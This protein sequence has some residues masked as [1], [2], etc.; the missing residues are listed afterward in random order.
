MT[1]F[2]R[3]KKIKNPSKTELNPHKN[4]SIISQINITNYGQLFDVLSTHTN[5]VYS[6][7]DIDKRLHGKK[8]R[9]GI[10]KA[11]LFE[12]QLNM[13]VLDLEQSDCLLGRCDDYR[14][15]S[16][17]AVESMMGKYFKSVKNYIIS[18]SFSSVGSG[19]L[20]KWHIWILFKTPKPISEIRHWVM[21]MLPK[22]SYKVGLSTAGAKLK[23]NAILDLAVLDTPNR[24]IY[25]HPLAG[26]QIE[27]IGGHEAL[28]DKQLNW[29]YHIGKEI[30]P[31]WMPVFTEEIE[32]KFIDKAVAA[33]R[34]G[35]GVSFD[36]HEYRQL[37]NQTKDTLPMNFV[38]DGMTVAG[39]IKAGKQRD[40]MPI[41]DSDPKYDGKMTYY[42]NH[43]S[44]E[45][46]FK[47]HHN[48][49]I[50]IPVP[51]AKA[52]AITLPYYGKYKPKTIFKET[53]KVALMQSETGSGKTY[54]YEKD[55][56][57]IIIVPTNVMV[58][59]L[60]GF[61]KGK[62]PE[63]LKDRAMVMTYDKFLGH[64]RVGS[65]GCEIEEFT[66]VVDE[67]HLLGD[68]EASSEIFSLFTRQDHPFKRVIFTSATPNI[69]AYEQYCDEIIV[70]KREDKVAKDITFIEIT[71]GTVPT[72]LTELKGT[73]LLFVQDKKTIDKLKDQFKGVAFT[74]N[75][76]DDLDLNQVIKDNS[77]IYITSAVREGFS[78]TEH[79]D[80]VVM[81]STPKYSISP[82]DVVQI[83]ARVRNNTPNIYLPH[84]SWGHS[85]IKKR[86][87]YIRKIKP[88]THWLNVNK[89]VY[90]GDKSTEVEELLKKHPNY[91]QQ[92][93]RKTFSESGAIRVH[94]QLRL[95]NISHDYT[96]TMFIDEMNRYGSYNLVI[97]K[98]SYK[99]SVRIAVNPTLSGS[100][101]AGH[102]KD[103]SLKEQI[104]YI[105]GFKGD[106][107]LAVRELPK[108]M[109]VWNK[110]L[111]I[112]KDAITKIIHNWRH[113][114]S[115]VMSATVANALSMVASDP[116]DAIKR[117][118]RI[119][120]KQAH[121]SRMFTSDVTLEIVGH[122]DMR[123]V[124]PIELL[125]LELLEMQ[126]LD[127]LHLA[128]AA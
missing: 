27:V 107:E 73:T 37:L 92:M 116:E 11:S 101:S 69:E 21:S 55:P 86:K 78:I 34:K 32:V 93:Y 106:N 56:Q 46:L 114:R 48:N 40:F 85:D 3:G 112:Q 57:V 49:I 104:E 121:K 74:A 119:E 124:A 77:F 75:T 68:R 96:R 108:Y 99:S 72:F 39:I 35:C 64:Y 91:K 54:Q 20:G 53:T 82:V 81:L 47:D 67:C 13:C 65:L 7:G 42:P 63:Y 10:R 41:L 43:D 126:G 36:E 58:A 23:R 118:K 59:G 94:T 9:N 79:V 66:L 1:L 89:K 117:V 15:D 87:S 110:H 14:L 29:N 60:K 12:S 28:T 115:V 123:L 98:R 51:V 45:P 83:S 19:V 90:N 50:Y 88:F 122:K 105:Y 71:H 109:C 52:K 18:P 113:S 120:L 16:Y 6:P 31:V 2:T 30:E 84:K 61:H 24:L 102:D 111:Y 44:G 22:E 4:D 103:A 97:K 100:L 62:V 5:S 26:E 17:D 125:D 33:K 8:L 95:K 38:L 25:E 76:K 128:G 70:H 127:V 80:N